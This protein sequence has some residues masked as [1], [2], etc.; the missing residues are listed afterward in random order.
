VSSPDRQTWAQFV[1]T[2]FFEQVDNESTA[3]F[4]WTLYLTLIAAGVWN[5]Y[6][7][8]PPLTLQMSLSVIS[9]KTW[10]LLNI[11]GPVNCAAGRMLRRSSESKIRILAQWMRFSG[12]VTIFVA[13]LCYTVA[14][15][16]VEHWGKGAF[17][18]FLGIIATT[19]AVYLGI[20]AGIALYREWKAD[21]TAP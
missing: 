12:D 5:L 17:G 14:T 15:F 9:F 6:A 1:G 2:K 18:G 4:A 16:T 21:H 3:L 8:T 10:I 7:D 20:G 19:F 13:C 11:T